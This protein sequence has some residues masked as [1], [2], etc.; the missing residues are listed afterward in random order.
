MSSPKQLVS[1]VYD[2][3]PTKEAPVFDGALRV[4]GR[5]CRARLGAVEDLIE[6]YA[7]PHIDV[8][9]AARDALSLR[10]EGGWGISCGLRRRGWN[11]D[12]D[13]VGLEHVIDADRAG[14]GTILWQMS[15]GPATPF[16]NALADAGFPLVH[17]SGP[18]HLVR[19]DD[20]WATR[21]ESPLLRLGECR[22][23]AERLEVS[24]D[25]SLGYLKTIAD[26]LGSNA[27]VSIRGDM[28]R[29][30]TNVVA[31]LLGFDTPFPTGAPALAHS[32]GAAL[33]PVA[34]MRLG[35]NRYR[36]V[37]EPPIDVDRTLRRAEFRRLAVLD[38][39]ARLDE[40]V[41]LNPG[42]WPGWPAIAR[43][44]AA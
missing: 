43:L 10:L 12:V 27:V 16:H 5:V 23:L 9:Q 2:E 19:H 28:T 37:V 36:V 17:L 21:I 13:I 15:F 33:M 25:G 31:P 14:A 38:Y 34:T 4:A 26:R 32:T 24:T 35:V 40:R 8:P 11:P 3:K 41:R 7:A 18:T 6:R 44:E 1:R 20:W 29:G 30:R 22:R 39:V 42:S